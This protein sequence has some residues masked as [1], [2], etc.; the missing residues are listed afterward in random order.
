MSYRVVR[1]VNSRLIY[2]E[3]QPCLQDM[4]TMRHRAMRCDNASMLL[5]ASSNH[6]YTTV[7]RS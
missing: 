3:Q 7:C 1:R 4:K 5:P 6:L 2:T